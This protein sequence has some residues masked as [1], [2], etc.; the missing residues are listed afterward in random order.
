[1]NIILLK[2]FL[3]QEQIA[4]LERKFPKFEIVPFYNEHI[5]GSINW[6]KVKIVYGEEIT[7][8]EIFQMP[9]LCWIHSPSMFVYKMALNSIYKNRNIILSFSA[10]KNLNQIGE[11]AE[12]AMLL[13]AKN[14]HVF[15]SKELSVAQT[16]KAS[17]EIWNLK[18]SNFLQIGM[19]II[20]KEICRR[21]KL[22]GMQNYAIDEHASFSPYCHK[23][24]N[25]SNL[26]ALLPNM[27]VVCVSIP[28]K[29]SPKHILK[30][31]ELEKIK[32]G[33]ILIILGSGGIEI[34]ALEKIAL[35]KQLR[36]V[37]LDSPEHQKL[38]KKKSLLLSLDNIIIADEISQKPD[39]GDETSFKSFLH[40]LRCFQVENFEAMTGRVL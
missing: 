24:L 21:T 16:K 29:V 22:L 33:S 36:G 15:S 8:E 14:L 30:Y 34:E 40:N 1:M 13:F 4:F 12:A 7:T 6:K 10:K 39:L 32:P 27:D 31:S 9:N 35:K 18:D 20:G 5:S 26:S 11:M 3:S 25:F 23:I 2:E 37:F 38:I 28:N 19:G 17:E